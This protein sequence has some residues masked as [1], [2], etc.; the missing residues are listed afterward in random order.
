MINELDIQ[1]AVNKKLSDAGFNVISPETEEG[2]KKPAVF[3]AVYPAEIERLNY[4]MENVTDTIEILR[5][6]KT[7][8]LIDASEAAQ[9]IRRLMF[10]E[11]LCVGDRKL[12]ISK[13]R[14]EIDDYIL[15]VYF[16]VEF[17]NET[18]TDE[19]YETIEH[20]ETE[21]I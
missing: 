4:D 13:M 1:A 14:S 16:D 15:H 8:T 6:P 5:I 2:F 19:E 11:P 21:G 17:M 20:L 9:R 3:T 10:Y 7:E 12:T 18:P